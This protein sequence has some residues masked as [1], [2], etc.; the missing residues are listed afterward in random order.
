MKLVSVVVIVACAIGCKSHEAPAPGANAAKVAPPADPKPEA[1]PVAAVPAQTPV[2]RGA[3]LANA[4]G[5]PVCHTGIGP[6]GPDMDH[7][8]AGGLEMPD[9]IGTWISPNITQDKGTGIGGWTD[10]QIAR[11]IRQGLRPDGAQLYPIMPYFNYNVMTDDDVHALV[12]FLRTVK[13][14]EKV[15]RPNHD[16]KME[17]VPAPLPANA[18]DDAQHHGAYMTSL[19][20]CSHCHFTPGPHGEPQPDKMFAGGLEFAIPM[21]GTG[22]VFSANLTSD[23]ATGLGKWTEAQIASTIQTMMRPDGRQIQGPMLFLQGG[24]SQLAPADIRAVAAYIHA[25][26][27]VNHAVPPSTFKPAGPPPR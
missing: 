19:M 6:H 2:E 18:P 13:P 9:A 3:Y 16:L 25:L 20:L 11:A 5:C 10:D 4:T 1:V 21:L 12:A 7:A 27:P 8:Y 24:W 14:V 17:K 15:V 22:S 23:P 26:P